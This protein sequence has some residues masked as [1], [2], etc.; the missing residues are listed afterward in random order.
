MVAEISIDLAQL[1]VKNK[2][3]EK[4]LSGDTKLVEMISPKYN[5]S[6][7][8]ISLSKAWTHMHINKTSFI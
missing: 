4:I 1:A 7:H 2:L 6:Q 3:T 8:F 5:A